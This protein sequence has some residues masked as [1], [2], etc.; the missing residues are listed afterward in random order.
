LQ[1]QDPSAILKENE[2]N[3]FLGT[4]NHPPVDQITLKRKE[5]KIDFNLEKIAKESCLEATKEE[6]EKG[7][8][9]VKF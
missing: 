9:K 6:I 2:S 3:N 4:L 8:G 7:D 5:M 1:R